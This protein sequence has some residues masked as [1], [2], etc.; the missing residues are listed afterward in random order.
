[1]KL[2]IRWLVTALA[3]Y[4][5][6]NIVPGI[7]IEGNDAALTVIIMALALGLVNA[8]VRPILKLLSCGLILLTL[9]IFLLVINAFS[10]WLASYIAVNWFDVGFH[11][12][13]FWPALLGSIVVS[14]VSLV[15][16]SIL[17]EEPEKKPHK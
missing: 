9:G 6:A 3:L 4:I 13:G 5:A 10:F 1:M 8:L 14:L 11:V 7:E 16:N 2:I 15:L 17:I 12:E